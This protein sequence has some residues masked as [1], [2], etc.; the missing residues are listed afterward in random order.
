MDPQLPVLLGKGVLVEEEEGEEVLAVCMIMPPI[1]PDICP[2]EVL[3]FTL[4][5][6]HVSPCSFLGHPR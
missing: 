2:R 6:Y 1:V 5:I 3:I 4:I